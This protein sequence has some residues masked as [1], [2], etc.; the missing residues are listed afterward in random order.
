MFNFLLDMY[1]LPFL[2]LKCPSFAT[3]S[4]YAFLFFRACNQIFYNQTRSTPG[5]GYNISLEH[6]TNLHY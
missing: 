4:V 3:I 6:I 2:P 1:F 5:L